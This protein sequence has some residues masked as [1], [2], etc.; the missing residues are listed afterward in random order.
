MVLR[1]LSMGFCIMCMD[2]MHWRLRNDP[3]KGWFARGFRS[4]TVLNNTRGRVT[5]FG[6]IGVG[7]AGAP[8]EAHEFYGRGDMESM[9]AS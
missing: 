5:V 4:T 3:G 9:L 1:Y 8:L 7:P 6:A 2:E